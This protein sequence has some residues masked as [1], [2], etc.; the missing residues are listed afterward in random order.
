MTILIVCNRNYN[1][2]QHTPSKMTIR[3]RKLSTE[4]RSMMISELPD[5]TLATANIVP[6]V[7]CKA[8]ML[9][10]GQMKWFASLLILAIIGT[11]AVMEVESK[12]TDG[13]YRTFQTRS[14][15]LQL[16]QNLDNYA[17]KNARPRYVHFNL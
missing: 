10:G 4:E 8:T 11:I 1:N 3:S 14:N 15:S 5:S 16:L 9:M 13:F 7:R 2:N 12:P 6:Q 17:A